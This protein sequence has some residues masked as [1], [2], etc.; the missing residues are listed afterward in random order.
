[1][2]AQASAIRRAI[3]E[4]DPSQAVAAAKPIE[5]YV[6]ESLARPKLYAVLVACFAVIAVMLAAIGVYG[7][8]AYVVSQ[9]T[10]EIGIRLALGATGRAVFAE[11]TRQGALLVTGGV[12]FGVAAAVLLRGTA[13]TLVFGIT[14]G[15]PLTYAAAATAFAIVAVAAVMIPA[16]RASRVDPIAALRHE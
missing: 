16:R 8:V 6:A 5:Q 4:V 15:D 14:P 13:S 3:H 10:H 11:L 9:R 7:L 2:S 12:V 1:M